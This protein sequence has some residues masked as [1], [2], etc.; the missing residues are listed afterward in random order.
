MEGSTHGSDPLSKSAV[1]SGKATAASTAVSRNVPSSPALVRKVY[2]AAQASSLEVYLTLPAG[3][4]Q[5]AESAGYHP[6]AADLEYHLML[7]GSVGP[8]V[9]LQLLSAGLSQV[10]EE[11]EGDNDFPSDG[12]DDSASS[13]ED[14]PPR[15]RVRQE[16]A[17][18]LVDLVQTQPM[19]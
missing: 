12:S 16:E 3:M 4:V 15:K 9:V 17:M 19:D 6:T 8:K 13:D 10:P 2:E 1:I 5:V 7:E 14:Q 18:D 11:E